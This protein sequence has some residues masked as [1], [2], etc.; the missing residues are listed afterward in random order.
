MSCRSYHSPEQEDCHP[1]SR[2]Q[3]CE[4]SPPPT[5]PPSNKVTGFGSGGRVGTGRILEAAEY[6]HTKQGDRWCPQISLW[7]HHQATGES[8]WVW[9]SISFGKGHKW[10]QLFSPG[11]RSQPLQGRISIK[12]TVLPH[13]RAGCLFCRVVNRKHEASLSYLPFF[14]CKETCGYFIKVSMA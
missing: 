5:S 1:V 7:H 3:D 6:G 12:A 4:L 2:R 8:P 13:R 14:C 10:N 9:K 11:G